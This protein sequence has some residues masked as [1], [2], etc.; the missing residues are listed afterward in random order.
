ML[1][2]RSHSSFFHTP[3]GQQFHSLVNNGRTE[4]MDRGLGMSPRPGNG[5]RTSGKV[6]VFLQGLGSLEV[7]LSVWDRTGKVIPL[8]LPQTSLLG[9]FFLIF[10]CWAN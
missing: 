10:F 4:G 9:L 1:F 8:L 7:A 6:P 2:Q 5:P 3:V